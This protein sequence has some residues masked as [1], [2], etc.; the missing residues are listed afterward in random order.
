[1][2]KPQNNDK[3]EEDVMKILERKSFLFTMKKPENKE[4]KEE[5]KNNYPT[6]RRIAYRR[7]PKKSRLRNKKYLKNALDKWR[8]NSKLMDNEELFDK[9]KKKVLHDL[10]KVYKKNE[11]NSLKEYFDKWKN[12]ENKE[13][14]EKEDNKD[15][16]EENNE[17][18]KEILK[19]KKKPRIEYKNDIIEDEDQETIKDKDTFKPVYVLPKQNLYKKMKEDNPNIDESIHEPIDTN[20]KTNNINKPYVKKYGQRNYPSKEN[21]IYIKEEINPSPNDQYLYPKLPPKKYYKKNNSNFTNESSSESEDSYLSG[22]TLIQNNK[23]IKEPRNYTSQSFFID[24][25]N[26]KNKSPNK[27]NEGIPINKNEIYKIN[28]IPNMMKGDFDT[29]IEK[30]PKILEK[31]NPRIQV[32]RATCDLT[33]IIN[34][35]NIN[36]NINANNIDDNKFL[37][38]IVKNCDHDLYA[39]QKSQSKKD[40][41]YSMTIPLNQLKQGLDYKN[42]KNK[43]EII[44]KNQNDNKY[45]NYRVIKPYK[46][47]N[48]EGNNYTLQEMNYSQY[49]KSPVR[50]PKKNKLE[51]NYKM[52]DSVIKI[53]GKQRKNIHKS[54]SPFDP[55]RRRNDYNS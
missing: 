38:K 48:P 17:E 33:N 10:F 37:E 40:K 32:T 2:K 13:N 19:Y 11:D 22:M 24:K 41:W 53:P 25:N 4:N 15:N 47:E 7:S 20:N 26:I 46:T 31:K 54:L 6:K 28:Q 49:Y 30:N 3:K 27:N 12:A 51:D 45:N 14:N 16:K 5:N 23:E 44:Q 39:N 9:Y 35:G 55:N 50:S 1:M 42:S 29:F 8:R 52:N 34:N 36:I 21:S 18:N 43:N